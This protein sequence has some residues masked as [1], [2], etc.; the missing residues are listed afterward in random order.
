MKSV[1]SLGPAAFVLAFATF[2]GPSVA[3]PLD[4]EFLTPQSSIESRCRAA[5]RGEIKGP[6][7]QKVVYVWHGPDGC[8]FYQQEQPFYIDK[9]LQCVA[10]GGPG[11]IMRRS[12]LQSAR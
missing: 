8:E 12:E 1:F 11:R 4:N 10:R 3:A 2:N 6:A 9:V 5:V 7:C